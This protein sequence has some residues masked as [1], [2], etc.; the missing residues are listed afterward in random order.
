MDVED[1]DKSGGQEEEEEVKVDGIV[2]QLEV[3]QSGAVK[4]RFGNGIVYDVRVPP[5]L[6]SLLH[7]LF[8]SIFNI[9]N[10]CRS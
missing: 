7:I 9:E 5:P 2:G 3:Y 10:T 1:K 6:Y 8:Y 4:M